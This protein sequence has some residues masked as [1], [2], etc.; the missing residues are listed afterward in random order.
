[1]NIFNKVALQGLKKNKT[2]TFVTIVG[3]ILSAALVTAGA[4]FGVSLLDYMVRG[5]QN[6]TGRWHVAFQEVDSSFAKERSKDK[7]AETAV[8]TE[9]LGYAELK[10]SKNEKSPY[11]FI[12]GYDEQAF[13]TLPIE[14]V[15]GRLPKNDSEILV[16]GGVITSGGVNVKE[17]D[18]LELSI[19]DRIRGGEKLGQSESYKKGEE[20]LVVREK[21]SY[22]VV[23]ICARLSYT[24]SEDP[25]YTLVTKVKAGEETSSSSVFIRLKNPRRAKAY[26]ESK[27][28]G[29]TVAMNNDVLRFMGASSN[30]VFTVLLYTVGGIAAGIVMLGSVFLIRNAFSISLNERARQFGILMSV[31]ATKKQ[32][33]DSVLFEGFCIGIAGIPEGVF[34][35]IAGTKAVLLF[36]SEKFQGMMYD[37]VPLKLVLWAPAILAA[38]L[39]S[40]ATILISAYLP[41]RKAVR[42]PVMECIRQTNEVKLGEKEVK[43]GRLSGY[44]FGL[45]GILAAKSFKRNKHRYRSIVL[46]LSLSV[47]IFVVTNSFVAEL[48]QA[49]E[50][51]IVFTTYNVA[52]STPDM[53]VT[54]EQIFKL[55][56]EF[57]AS[58]DITESYYQMNINGYT[59]VETDSLTDELKK[60]LKISGGKSKLKLLTSFQIVD[61][62]KYQR[63]VKEAGLEQNTGFLAIAAVDNGET[64]RVQEVDDFTNMFKNPSE[65]FTFTLPVK[66]EGEKAG[67]ESAAEKEKPEDA[68]A[69]EGRQVPVKLNFVKMI[70]PDILPTVDSEKVSEQMPYIFQVAVPYSMKDE[71]CAPDTHI[72]ARGLSISSDAPSQTENEMKNIISGS[73]MKGR[74]LLLN[75][76]KMAENNNNIIFIANTFSYIFIAMITLIAVANVFN[77]ISTNIKLRQRELAM[78]RSVGMSERS[79]QD[80]MNF[81]CILYGLRALLWGIPLSLF[82]SYAMYQLMQ[83]G[84]D[85]INFDIPWLAIALSTLGVFL[86]VFVTMLYSV[87]K[88]KKENIIDA[89]RDDMT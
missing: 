60:V 59:T 19:G 25:G 57:Q 56:D 35:G 69:K 42:T 33:R 4:T 66:K 18:T 14:L 72:S 38:A 55:W 31:G 21:R 5:A 82:T 53:S 62:D 73:D 67:T 71:L 15:S 86:I 87:S 20:K 68:E 64:N 51:A 24:D 84:A 85:N 77:T 78:L 3:V 83:F 89:L 10:G 44:L 52:F 58:E 39:I 22:T 13:D 54:D 80:M 34:L 40:F 26:A 16:S 9:N 48:K 30:D 45:P 11:V 6:K 29:C 2:R 79:F 17:G 70:M 88:I 7:E 46:S 43:T 1:M 32:L 74:Y 8:V 76:N 12:T 36:V 41:A 65:E 75:M 37:N 28:E 61:D 27:G 23:G 49:S 50:A 47:I 81:E 63:L